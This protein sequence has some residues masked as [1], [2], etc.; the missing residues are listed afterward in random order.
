LAAFCRLRRSLTR[1]QFLSVILDLYL[2]A[3]GLGT[4]V[5]AW[6]FT[7]VLTGGAVVTILITTAADTFGRKQ[8]LILGA[9]LM[10]LAGCVFALTRNPLVL[11]LAAVFGT[12]S[13]SR[14]EVRPFLSIKQAILPQTSQDLYR[15]KVFSVYN[16]VGSI[17]GAFG[18]H[19]C[20]ASRGAC[21]FCWHF[22]RFHTTQVRESRRYYGTYLVNPVLGLQFLLVGVLKIVLRLVD[23]R[24]FPEFATA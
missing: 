4:T 9:L 21:R 19:G 11:T 5:I 1:L 6:I 8:V 20:G 2:D 16:L 7:A 12:I 24:R 22:S 3:I 17:F 15:T 13:P 18:A 14:K 23:L 10:A